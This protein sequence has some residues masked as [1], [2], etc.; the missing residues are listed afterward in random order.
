MK[1]TV[2]I[3]E[4]NLVLILIGFEAL[5]GLVAVLMFAKF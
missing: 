1:M 3:K 2:G 5:C 4:H